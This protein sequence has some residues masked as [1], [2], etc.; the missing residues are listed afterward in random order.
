MYVDL[1]KCPL[2]WRLC[3]TGGLIIIGHHTFWQHNCKLPLCF[4]STEMSSLKC[5]HFSWQWYLST[6]TET[7]WDSMDIAAVFWFDEKMS[8]L[9][10]LQSSWQL[11]LA[12][13]QWHYFLVAGTDPDGIEVTVSHFSILYLIIFSE[14]SIGALIFFSRFLNQA[15]VKK[16]QWAFYGYRCLRTFRIVMRVRDKHERAC[17]W[18][19]GMRFTVPI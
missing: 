16:Y 15:H 7:D 5:V 11:N 14:D 3:R 9:S 6:D 13:V 18:E 4:Q 10:N 19:V 12:Q 17:G 2:H 8:K 1:A